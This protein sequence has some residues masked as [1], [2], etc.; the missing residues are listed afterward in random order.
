MLTQGFGSD[1]RAILRSVLR[2]KGKNERQDGPQVVMATATLT[3]AVRNLLSDVN[4]F[5]VEFADDTNITPRKLD[6][7]EQRVDMSVVEVD[8]VHRTLPHVQHNMEEVRGLDKILVLNNII[9]Q[10]RTRNIRT[11]IFCNTIESCR[12][13]EYALN[14]NEVP[15]LA[16]HGELRGTEREDNLDH[17]RSGDCQYLVCTDIAARGIDIPA[18]EHVI[19]FDFPLNPVDYIHRAGRTGR[20]GRKGIVTSLITK[21]DLVLSTA[22]EGAIARGLP[23]DSLSSSKRDYQDRARFA[24]V[25]G[26][27]PRGTPLRSKSGKT[28]YWRHMSDA[29]KVKEKTSSVESA[30]G[31]G[32]GRNTNLSAK[33]NRRNNSS[34][35]LK[36]SKSGLSGE[37][38][39]GMSGKGRQSGR[40]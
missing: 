10:Y 27:V 36:R 22:I 19:L 18:I 16:Y 14:E 7:T 4:G 23:I 2:G 31:V 17:F 6:G 30:K 1:I 33:K 15:A 25:V 13:V 29:N 12:A 34:T 5:N 11:L 37:S 24:E 39:G 9:E 40:R 26:R 8:G 28:K 20:A 32:K 3:K 38:S 35:G 21:R